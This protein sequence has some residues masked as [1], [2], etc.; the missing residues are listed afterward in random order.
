MSLLL[1]GD[2]SLG[3]KTRQI[4]WLE[5]PPVHSKFLYLAEGPPMQS[6]VVIITVR[7]CYK[8]TGSVQMSAWKKVVLINQLYLPYQTGQELG[9]G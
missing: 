5:G 1:T 4:F 6:S 8:W 7:A 9:I 2:S 3:V